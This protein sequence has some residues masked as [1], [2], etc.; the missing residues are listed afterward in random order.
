M[1]FNDTHQDGVTQ[2]KVKYSDYESKKQKYPD[3]YAGSVLTTNFVYSFL[4]SVAKQRIF[5]N[6]SSLR[7]IDNSTM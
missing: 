2:R 7:G 5:R 1:D 6:L 3:S 4:D